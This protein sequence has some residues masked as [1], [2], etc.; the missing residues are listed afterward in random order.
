MKRLVIIPAAGLATRMMPMSAS[1]SKAMIPV[2]GQPIL[3]HII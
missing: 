3:S 2:A 1:M